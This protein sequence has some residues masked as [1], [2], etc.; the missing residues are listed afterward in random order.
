MKN[1]IITANLEELTLSSKFVEFKAPNGVVILDIAK[2][3]LSS[4]ADAYFNATD[5]ARMFTGTA[6]Q[7][8]VKLNKYFTSDRTKAYLKVVENQLLNNV[9]HM[10]DITNPLK[11][12]VM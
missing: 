3:M 11:N 5:I 1:T 8:T 10:G 4:G 6:R 2:L 9:T 7:A 12:K